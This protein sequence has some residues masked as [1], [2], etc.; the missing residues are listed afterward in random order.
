M[1]ALY[2]IVNAL[3]AA[4]I[5]PAAIFLDLIFFRASTS[6][7]DAGLQEGISIKFIID[8]ITG[9]ETF[10]H[11]MLID[12]AGLSSLSWP[13]ELDPVKG[14]IIATLVFFALALVAALFIVIWSIC[15]NKR[16]PVIIASAAGL[17]STI[18]MIICFNSFAAPI[19]DGTINVIKIFSS[20]WLI[21][22]LG[23]MVSVDHLSMGGVHTGMI[24]LFIALIVWTGAFY[25]VEM[26]ETKEEK[27]A[28]K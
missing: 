26:G 1:K 14:Q 4:A 24:M 10:F 6:I 8:V 2:R 16:L 28:K 11:D 12:K 17:I 27:P 5:F 15:S 19:V 23:N 22:L 3:L 7:A 9:K 13:Q 21:G 18:V 25:L 20:N